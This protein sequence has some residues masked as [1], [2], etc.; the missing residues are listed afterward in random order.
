VKS[1]VEEYG[2]KDA[3]KN[4]PMI[5]NIKL[6]DNHRNMAIKESSRMNSLPSHVTEMYDSR[7]VPTEN[8]N[9]SKYEF[10]QSTEV[11]F[12]LGKNN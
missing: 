9:H 12:N 6:K 7:R 3:E 5:K 4:S 8:S 2:C 11:N 10:G 1:V